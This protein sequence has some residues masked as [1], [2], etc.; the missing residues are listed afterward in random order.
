MKE[1]P[2]LHDM[3]RYKNISVLEN[4]KR[5]F[6]VVYIPVDGNIMALILE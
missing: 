6:I 3:Y 2:G 4:R 5:H 1:T